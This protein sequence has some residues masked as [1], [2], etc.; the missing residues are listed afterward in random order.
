MGG[1]EVH[2]T[3]A[4]NGSVDKNK[5]LDGSLNFLELGAAWS[6]KLKGKPLS[7][8]L[9][10]R[11]A[12]PIPPVPKGEDSPVKIDQAFCTVKFK[13]YNLTI[14]AQDTHSGYE[15]HN[16]A[17]LPFVRRSWV[18][19]TGQVSTLE[20]SLKFKD[21]TFDTTV[22]LNTGNWAT[23]PFNQ[24]N[25]GLYI[26]LAF[27]LGSVELLGNFGLDVLRNE[28]R[29][30]ILSTSDLVITY[31]I[32]KKFHLGLNYTVLLDTDKGKNTHAHGGA[33]YFIYRPK[34][35]LELALRAENFHDSSGLFS[36]IPHLSV[37]G[38]TAAVNFKIASGSHL[39]QARLEGHYQHGF[40]EDSESNFIV[41]A[42][43]VY[44]FS[45]KGKK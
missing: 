27:H 25:L 45:V 20:T 33:Y 23:F 22:G 13:T 15:L 17:T 30:D 16:P 3:A 12:T 2:G 31:D 29:G 36:G 5:K 9:D 18:Y 37:F 43:L 28:A 19:T 26:G 14:G 44:S 34:A 39:F 24:A 1:F 11:A 8:Q 42:L 6:G 10:L 40:T 4:L 32:S 41:G 21:K 35:W 7:C 38:V